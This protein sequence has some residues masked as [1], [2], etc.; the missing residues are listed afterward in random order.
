[1]FITCTAVCPAGCFNGGNC[2]LPGLCACPSGWTGI[3]CS[4]I[5]NTLL[6]TK[7]S[8]HITATITYLA[9]ACT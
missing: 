1:M 9:T 6:R 2:F 5:H 3:D 7:I 8:N 4:E